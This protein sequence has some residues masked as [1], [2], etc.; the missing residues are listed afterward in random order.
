MSRITPASQCAWTKFEYTNLKTE[1]EGILDDFLAAAEG[2]QTKLIGINILI[3]G[4]M[5]DPRNAVCMPV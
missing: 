2:S 1:H 5:A 3:F 4:N